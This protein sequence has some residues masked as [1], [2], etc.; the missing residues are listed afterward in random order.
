MH[1][2]H[3]FVVI[4]NCA[5]H[6]LSNIITIITVCHIFWITSYLNEC[7]YVPFLKII[8]HTWHES[9][10]QWPRDLKLCSAAARLLRLWVRIPPGSWMDVCCERFVL[11]GKCLCD[12]MITRPVESYRLWCVVV[13]DL[14]TSW[15]RRPWPAGGCCARNKQTRHENFLRWTWINKADYS[16]LLL[17]VI[18]NDSNRGNS[19]CQQSW[20]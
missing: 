15:M 1:C 17:L 19:S 5:A 18:T 2:G 3:I 7:V 6:V 8:C 12:G 20:M 13:C 14:N 16:R 10:F 11:S 9:R 4:H